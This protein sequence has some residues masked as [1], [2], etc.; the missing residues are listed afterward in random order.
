MKKNN[1]LIELRG[2]RKQE[3]IAVAIGVSKEAIRAYENGSR[4]P[5]H[6]KMI[7]LANYYGVTVQELFFSEQK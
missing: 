7:K 3:E 5:K 6:E 4:N 1:K 2:A